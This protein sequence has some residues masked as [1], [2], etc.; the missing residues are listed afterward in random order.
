[1]LRRMKNVRNLITPV[2]QLPPEILAHIAVFFPRERDLINAT[3]VCH[4]WRTILLSFPRLWPNAG[5]L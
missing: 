2:N 5:G 3:A 4:R 1:M